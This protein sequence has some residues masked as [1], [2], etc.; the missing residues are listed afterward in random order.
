ML[1]MDTAVTV[2]MHFG[3]SLHLSLPMCVRFSLN[4]TLQAMQVVI[5]TFMNARMLCSTCSYIHQTF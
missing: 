4:N 1:Y 5:M 2:S 3:Y